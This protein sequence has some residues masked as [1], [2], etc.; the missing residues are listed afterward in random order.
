MSENE[1]ERR[2]ETN[3]LLRFLGEVRSNL[4]R[5]INGLEDTELNWR[6]SHNSN[7]IGNL[8]NHIAGAEGFWIHHIV[9]D[10][11]TSRNRDSEFEVKDFHVADLVVTLDNVTRTTRAVLA[12][13]TDSDLDVQRTYWSNRTGQHKQ[14][15]I[16]WCILHIIEH[17][18]LHIGQVFFIRKMY[19]DISDEGV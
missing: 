6:P 3:E 10:M 18:A 7:S 8:L 16:R 15:T 2:T 5:A 12:E 4:N 17:S 13:L 1:F 11:P 14:A 9:G 19:N